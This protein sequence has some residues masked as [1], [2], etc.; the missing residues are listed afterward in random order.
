MKV[1]SLLFKA[2]KCKSQADADN[3]LATLK[4]VFGNA[5]PVRHLALVAR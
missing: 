1:K 2:G 3:L 5:K 4:R